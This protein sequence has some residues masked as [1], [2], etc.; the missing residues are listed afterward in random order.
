MRE[1]LSFYEFPGDD[2]DVIKGSA[3]AATTDADPKI[4]KEAILALMEAVEKS[5][6]TPTRETDKPFLMPVE[7]TFSISGR[8][9]VV[10]GRV[11]MGTIRVGE[12]VEIVGLTQKPAKTTCTGALMYISVFYSYSLY[13]CTPSYKT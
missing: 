9:T 2:I 7:D 4:G 12:E 8:G 3:L 6:P 1:L 11:E 10:T 13:P 5:I